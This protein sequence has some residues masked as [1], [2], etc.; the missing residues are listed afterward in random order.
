MH[1]FR[2]KLYSLIPCNKKDVSNFWC[3][4]YHFTDSSHFSG[5]FTC[6]KIYENIPDASLPEK[7]SLQVTDG[8]GA[9]AVVF[10]KIQKTNNHYPQIE[11]F[12]FQWIPIIGYPNF[13]WMDYPVQIPILRMKWSD[14]DS[15]DNISVRYVVHKTYTLLLMHVLIVVLSI[16]FQTLHLKLRRRIKW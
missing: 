2:M 11:P 16:S 3:C 14:L 5:S 7:M 4:C 1:N 13:I 12:Q 10:F 9:E 6:A 15:M 8:N